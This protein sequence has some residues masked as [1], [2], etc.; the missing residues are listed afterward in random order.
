MSK[1]Y[2]SHGDWFILSAY[3]IAGLFVVYLITYGLFSI[4]YPG[5]AIVLDSL[6]AIVVYNAIT[7]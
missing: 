7:E 4:D 5:L 6:L 2:R 1:I 3:W